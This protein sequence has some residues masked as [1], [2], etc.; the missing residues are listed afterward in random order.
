VFRGVLASVQVAPPSVVVATLAPPLAHEPTLTRQ[1]CLSLMA[2]R[3]VC[4]GAAELGAV[5]EGVGNGERDGEGPA[6]VAEAL[7]GA[8]VE[9]GGVVPLDFRARATIAVVRA[10]STT[11]PAVA[12]RE[13]MFNDRGPFGSRG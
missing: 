10:A 11:R 9:L 13:E 3:M 12:A 5:V 7:K 1:A 4:S 2:T 6:E 8:E